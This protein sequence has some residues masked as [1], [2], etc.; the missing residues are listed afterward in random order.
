MTDQHEEDT[1]RST[2]ASK[3]GWKNTR[4]VSVKGPEHASRP[5][6]APQSI[7]MR[8]HTSDANTGVADHGGALE[9]EGFGLNFEAVDGSASLPSGRAA[10]AA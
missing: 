2:A 9:G 1:F 7:Q 10:S 5:H 4:T 3:G 6:R 8:R